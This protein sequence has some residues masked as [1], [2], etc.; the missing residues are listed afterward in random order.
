ML[1]HR[2]AI[3]HASCLRGAGDHSD[4]RTAAGAIATWEAADCGALR[5]AVSRP[6][7]PGCRRWTSTSVP[8]LPAARA[9]RAVAMAMR[10]ESQDAGSIP[11]ACGR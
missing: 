4:S 8:R 3:G 7:R 9:A 2:L 10:G 1:G 6:V 5:A 11:T